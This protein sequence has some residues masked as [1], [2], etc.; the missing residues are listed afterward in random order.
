MRTLVPQDA[1]GDIQLHGAK[2][3][4][5]DDVITRRFLEDAVS[6]SGQK[7][8]SD[9]HQS[10]PRKVRAAIETDSFVRRIIQEL[11]TASNINESKF[12]ALFNRVISSKNEAT[13]SSVHDLMLSFLEN[14]S[15]S[16]E[17]IRN[18]VMEVARK[19]TELRDMILSLVRLVIKDDE[20]SR[21]LLRSQLRYMVMSDDEFRSQVRTL[22]LLLLADDEDTVSSY[23]SMLLEAAGIDDS[24]FVFREKFFDLM[25]ND[26]SFR[27]EFERIVV[28]DGLIREFFEDILRKYIGVLP[29]ETPKYAL[30]SPDYKY[31]KIDSLGRPVQILFADGQSVMVSYR[32]ESQIDYFDTAD[33]K[34]SFLYNDDGYF[35]GKKTEPLSLISSVAND[36]NNILTPDFV[37]EEITEDGKP[38]LVKYDDNQS[39]IYRYR[40]DGQID[41]YITQGYKVQFQYNDRGLF[42]GKR[43]SYSSVNLISENNE[44][45]L[46]TLDYEYTELNKEGN[47]TKIV[48]SNGQEVK[49]TY[50]ENGQMKF[51]ETMGHVV[52]FNYDSRDIL[53]SQDTEILTSVNFDAYMCDP[54]FDIL[55]FTVDG[56]KKK[57]RYRD[58]QEVEYFYFADGRIN[59]YNTVGFQVSYRYDSNKNLTQIAGFA[60]SS[61]ADISRDTN[62]LVPRN[63]LTFLDFDERNLPAQATF[64]DAQIVKFFYRDDGKVDYITTVGYKVTYLYNNRGELNGQETEKIDPNTKI[65]Y[66]TNNV[67]GEDF[68]IEWRNKE[69]RPT[70]I[71]YKDGSVV[72]VFYHEDNLRVKYFYSGQYKVRFLYDDSLRFVGQM[73][74]LNQD[75]IF[76]I[77]N[78]MSLLV[79]CDFSVTRLNKCNLPAEIK[80]KNG[81]VVRIF[82]REDTQIDIVETCGYATKYH[83]NLNGAF[84]GTSRHELLIEDLGLW[85]NLQEKNEEPHYDPNWFGV[86]VGEDS[87]HTNTSWFNVFSQDGAENLG[88][89]Y[90]INQ[91]DVYPKIDLRWHPTFDP[92]ENDDEYVWLNT[93]SEFSD[94]WLNMISENDIVSQQ[95]NSWFDGN[96]MDELENGLRWINRVGYDNSLS[97]DSWVNM[98][99]SSDVVVES[100]YFWCEIFD[101]D[102]EYQGNSWCNTYPDEKPDISG[103]INKIIHQG[104]KHSV[105]DNENKP[106]ELEFDN[107]QIVNY[108]YRGDGRLNYYTTLGY[109]VLLNYDDNNNFVGKTTEIVDVHSENDEKLLISPDY[110]Y[111]IMDELN[112]LPLEIRYDDGSVASIFYRSDYQINYYTFLNNRVTFNYENDVFVG[113]TTSQLI[114]GSRYYKEIESVDDINTYF[115]VPRLYFGPSSSPRLEYI[116]D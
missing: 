70:R 2:F 100:I 83:Y 52:F 14:D 80:Y 86:K 79:R 114:P 112:N 67:I 71:K 22:L 58:G 110:T 17:I 105:L 106:L 33:F 57:V 50:R 10:V 47:P 11:A 113:K 20:I 84:V 55:E 95:D 15:A 90:G 64:S 37:F 12:V 19:N 39:V 35:I 98:E 36:T 101:D 26:D 77:E 116:L 48:F 89:Y 16:L 7:I 107:G 73:T 104:F 3:E 24:G 74:T 88:E 94:S 45:K 111:T 6:D 78:D 82:Y 62:K 81:Q 38:L 31:T 108:A 85:F 76:G 61:D 109:K 87:V 21:D 99:E 18:T 23:R 66:D 27:R 72:R 5:E 115:S 54:D 42:I 13:V 91:S 53:V 92:L 65:E 49:I 43:T 96:M 56:K 40:S 41:N 68:I 4:H 25:K 46:L 75:V 59:Y 9:V 60:Y 69:S 93:E 103:D 30:L 44:E 51:L 102:T 32:N 63:S 34:V 28:N 29:D 97:T 1:Y 8:L